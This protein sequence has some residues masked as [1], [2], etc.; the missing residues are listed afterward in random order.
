MH[1]YLRAIGFSDIKTRPELNKLFNI[2]IR[3]PTTVNNLRIDEELMYSEISLEFAEGIGITIRGE[4][5]SKDKFHIE[6]YFPFISGNEISTREEIAINK[7]VDSEAYTGMCDDFRLGVSL[8]FYLQNALEYRKNKIKEMSFNK[9]FNVYLSSLSLEGSILLP[10]DKTDDQ[11]KNIIADAKYRHNLISE[12]KK[13]NQDAIDDLTIDDIDTY[14]M[15]SK[16][17]RHEDIYSIVD[18]SFIPYGSE[19]DN[20]SIIATI[21]EVELVT[22]THTKEKMYDMKLLCN[23]VE[24]RTCINK[25]DLIGEPRVGRRFKGNIWLQANIHFKQS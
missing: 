14:A 16:R 21:K 6:N 4:Y 10:M 22:N 12:A 15:V 9:A 1:S 18:T 24:I 2:I 11:K 19:S 23:G 13:G 3:K 7:K 25:E 17:I 8:I 5:D 20:Y